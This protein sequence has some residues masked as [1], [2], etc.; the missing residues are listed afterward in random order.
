MKMP[1]LFNCI[2]LKLTFQF[3]AKIVNY[4]K[5]TFFLIY[6]SNSCFKKI[7]LE[8][9]TRYYKLRGAYKIYEF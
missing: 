7:I 8:T 2:F 1:R 9:A 6:N 5:D 4:F 3:Q